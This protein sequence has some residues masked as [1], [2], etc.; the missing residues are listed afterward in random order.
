MTARIKSHVAGTGFVAFVA[1]ACVW[2]PLAAQAQ[3]AA[4]TKLE[5]T[6]YRAQFAGWSGIVFRCVHDPHRS[7][8]VHV[9]EAA[10]KDAR[11]KAKAAKVP[12]RAAKNQSYAAAAYESA[13]IG[14]GLIV[15]ADVSS[16]ATSGFIGVA[17]RIQVGNSY[18]S[19][20]DRKA[21]S[22]TPEA[23]PRAGKLVLWEKMDV[24]CGLARPEFER[25]VAVRLA[26]MFGEFFDR[27]VDNWQAPVRNSH[28]KEAKRAV[29]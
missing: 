17:L 28:A 16:S 15:E 9:C 3:E 24:A 27:F 14:G 12:F 18:S 5:R 8:D 21:A 1:A 6:F 22:G 25:A 23:S 7:F 10:T 11:I 26:G 20:V 19:V 29:R 13:K 2:W 4:T